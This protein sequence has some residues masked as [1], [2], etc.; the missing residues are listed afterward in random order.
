MNAG[1]QVI[2]LAR[3][4]PAAK[5]L[6]A[7][8]AKVHRG[9]LQNLESLHNGSAMSDGVIH[10]GFIHKFSK[11]KESSEI[12]RNAIEA[13]G[14]ALDGSDCPLIITSGIGLFLLAD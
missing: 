10:T 13:L 5:S 1:H 7:T 6:A 3:S 2:W 14:S 8:G 12:D 4:D 9:D 11:F